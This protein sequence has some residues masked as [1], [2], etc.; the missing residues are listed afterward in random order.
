MQYISVF[1]DIANLLIYGEKML[2]LAELK[3][4]VT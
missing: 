4:Y 3:E 2:M 1:L